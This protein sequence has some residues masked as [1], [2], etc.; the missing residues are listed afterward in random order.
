MAQTSDHSNR[1][2]NFNF[3]RFSKLPIELRFKIWNE[4][5]PGPRIVSVQYDHGSREHPGRVWKAR[6][7]DPRLPKYFES[8]SADKSIM[9]LL[10]T[11]KESRAITK[12][13]Y[14]L[15][16]LFPLTWFSFPT[17]FLCIKRDDPYAFHRQGSSLDSFKDS[18]YD[19]SR[20]Q[21]L[22]HESCE[23]VAQKTRNLV[24][25]NTPSDATSL[26][27]QTEEWLVQTLVTFTGTKVLIT[28]DPLHVGCENDEEGV[29]LRGELD[30]KIEGNKGII[31][32]SEEDRCLNARLRA[33]T[34]WIDRPQWRCANGINEEYFQRS[35]QAIM[36]NR[37]REIPTV[38][39]KSI[40][41]ANI[42][43]QLID[44]CGSEDNLRQFPGRPSGSIRNGMRYHGSLDL[45]QEI[46]YLELVLTRMPTEGVLYEEHPRRWKE[47]RFN[48]LGKIHSLK[49]RRDVV[50]D[51]RSARIVPIF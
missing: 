4:E 28:A 18:Y 30:N 47:D 27:G 44:I 22:A 42:K 37:G 21:Y 40:T 5:L 38:I 1:I 45:E 13:R 31:H 8:T 20:D 34:V 33:M 14:S 26:P 48:L 17:D 16:T 25:Y 50:K 41:A 35:W 15:I 36:A 2:H 11:C 43:K 24:M 6:N 7:Q 39:R 46:A 23:D 19:C 32:E 29:W 3:P 12:A 51:L 49:F 10:H 9:S